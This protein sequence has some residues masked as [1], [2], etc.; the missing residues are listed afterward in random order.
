MNIYDNI[1]VNMWELINM[2]DKELMKMFNPTLKRRGRTYIQWK[3][4]L[5]TCLQYNVSSDNFHWTQ[6]APEKE[7]DYFILFKC[8]D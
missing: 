8:G 3:L 4:S 7:R 5:D 2:K 6:A 1:N